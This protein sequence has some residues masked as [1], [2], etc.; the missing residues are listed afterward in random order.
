MQSAIIQGLYGLNVTESFKCPGLCD[1]PSSYISLGYKTECRNVTQETMQAATCDKIS[2]LEVCNMTTPGG[3]NLTTRHV[4]TDSGTTYN[5]NTSSVL[6]TTV[7]GV[8]PSFP[9]IM[10][11][12]I[13]RST[14]GGNFELI[15]LN[16]TECS[17]SLTAHEYTSA[18]ANGSDFSVEK[19][20]VDFGVKNPWRLKWNA[21]TELNFNHIYTN[22]TTNGDFHIPALEMTYGTLAALAAFFQSTTVVSDWITGN[23]RKQNIGF[24]TA[25]T[26]DVDLAD[27]FDKMANG[28]SMYVRYGPNS[29]PAHGVIKQSEP[30][31]FI[32]W[33]YFIVPILIEAFAILF[34]I[35]SI[36]SNRPSRR[37]PMWKSSTLAVLACQHE[38]RLG[39][40]QTTGKD[41]GDLEIEAK[42]AEVQLG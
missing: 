9:E 18:R 35:L 1:W 12:G 24:S 28:M 19:R 32:R 20:E 30:H 38:E 6:D 37:V 34:A 27:R 40:L 14:M 26:G 11:F 16:I 36:F 41:L 21:S 25:L 8:G 15:N 23:V 10:R 33:R 42:K 29:L 5:M 4:F 31:V 17:L 3:V 2:S 13:F 7:F 22:E 39:L